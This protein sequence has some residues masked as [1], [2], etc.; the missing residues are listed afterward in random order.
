VKEPGSRGWNQP[1]IY[2][3]SDKR[4]YS[5]STIWEPCQT[6]IFGGHVYRF[7]RKGTGFQSRL[8]V[9]YQASLL[10]FLEIPHF[11]LRGVGLTESR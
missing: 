6:S 2:V 11:E 7:L 10:D 1:P 4:Q 3:S 9:I 5:T 8:R